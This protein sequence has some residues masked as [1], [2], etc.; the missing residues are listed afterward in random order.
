MQRCRAMFERVYKLGFRVLIA[1]CR[2][3]RD[4]RNGIWESGRSSKERLSRFLNQLTRQSMKAHR[5][6]KFTKEL[7]ASATGI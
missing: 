2:S 6:F 1:T 5:L 3:S 7:A 4:A